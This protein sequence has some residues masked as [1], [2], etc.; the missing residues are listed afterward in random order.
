MIARLRFLNQRRK[1]A[2]SREKR[3]V[4]PRENIDQ[5]SYKTDFQQEWQGWTVLDSRLWAENENRNKNPCGGTRPN[6]HDRKLEQ[7]QN[8][9][10][11]LY[12]KYILN[13]EKPEVFWH[14]L[15]QGGNKLSG[16]HSLL[17]LPSY[18]GKEK[19]G[20][21]ERDLQIEYK[22]SFTNNTN[23][24]NNVNNKRKYAKYTKLI[25]SFPELGGGALAS[26]QQLPGSTRQS[27]TG[28]CS[29][30]ELESGMQGLG[31]GSRSRAGQWAS[32]S[33]EVG[34]GRGER[35]P[36]DPPALN[37]VWCAWHGIPRTVSGRLSCPPVFT[38]ATLYDS[39]LERPKRSTGDLGCYSDNYKQGPFSAF[40]C[41]C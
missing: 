10:V 36:H 38:R 29:G 39:S 18:Q 17:T 13:P 3:Q 11:Q 20:K 1:R 28:P 37:W 7:S 2:G 22:T 16:R 8:G 35:D 32:S 21:R 27:Q 5:P 24:T 26:R 30:Q 12:H 9:S 25:L 15:E 4:A 19:R 34:H 23:N 6:C 14:G 33:S 40:L 41:Y 31:S